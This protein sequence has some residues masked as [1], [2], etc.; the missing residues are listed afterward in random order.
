MPPSVEP[1]RVHQ[2]HAHPAA[3]SDMPHRGRQVLFRRQDAGGTDDEVKTAIQLHAGDDRAVDLDTR[4]APA[5]MHEHAWMCVHS[6]DLDSM[7]MKRDREPSG[8]DAQVQ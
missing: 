1:V 7:A 3:W 2:L 6:D 4:D 5:N 8:A